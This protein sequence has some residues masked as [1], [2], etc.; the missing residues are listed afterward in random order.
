MRVKT[1]FACWH[2]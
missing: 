2:W 1:C